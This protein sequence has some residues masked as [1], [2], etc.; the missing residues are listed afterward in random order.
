M[1]QDASRERQFRVVRRLL[2]IPYCPWRPNSAPQVQFLLDMNEEALFGGA[3]GPGKSVGLLMAASQFLH[4]PGYAALL[5]RKTFPDLNRPRALMDY[6]QQWWMGKPGVRFDRE[7]HSYHFSCPGGGESTIQ[8]GSLDT[9]F[10]RYK[11]QSAAYQFC[12]FD[13]LTQFPMEDYLFLF[14]RLRRP[15]STLLA[16]VPLRQ[17][18]A[19]N[20]GGR[21]HDW[22]YQRFIAPWEAWRQGKA[23]EPEIR[24]YPA[25]VWDNP[26]LDV[27]AYVKSLAK[28]DP[29]TRAQLMH[30]DW[31]IRPEGR[32]FKRTWFHL[33]DRKDLPGNC[34][35]VRAWDMAA[36]ENRPGNDP[37]Y[38]VGLRM[39]RSPTTGYFYIDDMRRWREEP[40]MNDAYCRITVQQDTRRVRQVMEQEPAAS[41]KISIRH[42]RQGPFAGSH[43]TA[44][45]STGKA[46]GR[47]S[48]VRAGRYTPQAKVDAAGP[49]SSHANAGEVFIVVDGSWDHEA[50]LSE[51][52]VFPDGAKDDVVDA[53]SLALNYLTSTP[54]LSFRITDGGN[55]LTGE[56][57][58][59]PSAMQWPATEFETGWMGKHYEGA[60]EA[61]D[62]AAVIQQRRDQLQARMDAIWQV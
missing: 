10:D 53:C 25:S 23:T 5:L 38:T 7:Q 50:F 44:V 17:R 42:Y 43:F 51:L 26:D 18:S 13:E 30:G 52:E 57:Y 59:V 62:P 35:W 4:V 2:D 31:S 60:A 1:T 33:I 54:N 27:E 56:N 24:F 32:M 22:V 47:V 48:T 11:F 21:F 15:A 40:G 20:P 9:Q 16:R 55:G 3:A 58:W 61:E 39:G 12:G 29:V 36:T 34:R 6:A 14:S 19:T 37:D 28:L 46:R 41:G 49:L 45:P 8:F